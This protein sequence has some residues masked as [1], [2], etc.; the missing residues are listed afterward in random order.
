MIAQALVSVAVSAQDVALAIYL[1]S[2]GYSSSEIG[3]VLA[4]TSI[5]AITLL[6][7]GGI[8]ADSYGRMRIAS[9]GLLLGSLSLFG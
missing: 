8:L 9:M 2:T 1:N 5:T 3:L 7:P 6:L 4:I